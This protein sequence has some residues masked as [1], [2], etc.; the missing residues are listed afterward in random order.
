MPTSEPADQKK[1]E[2]LSPN[3]ERESAEP[4]AR[5]EKEGVRA[6]RRLCY[7][8][9]KCLKR[10]GDVFSNELGYPPLSND[11]DANMLYSLQPQFSLKR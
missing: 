8:M 1:E 10:S 9:K 4:G 7:F 2:G 6:G 5:S 3:R 11:R